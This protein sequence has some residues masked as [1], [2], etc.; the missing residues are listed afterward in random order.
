MKF[1]IIAT[2]L[3]LV[4]CLFVSES[5]SQG[6]KPYIAIVKTKADVVKGVLYK[7]DSA[8]VV[9][10]VEG[11][12]VTLPVD[13]IK[14][15]K[16]RTPKKEASIIQFLKY[17]PWNADN[18]EKRADGAI[19][20]K[21]GEKDPTPGEEVGGHVVATVVNITGNIIAAPIQAINPSIANY[22]INGDAA[23]YAQHKTDLDYF[24]V[25]YQQNTNLTT[26]LQKIKAISA[27]FKP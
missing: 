17:D 12:P 18:Y 25:Y 9:M 1:K 24:S 14:T 11:S 8:S 10:I 23:K 26:E 16:I 20:R 22:K 13:E 7:V 19:V 21:W 5:K 15:I 27:S 2:F 4:A 6:I 3:M